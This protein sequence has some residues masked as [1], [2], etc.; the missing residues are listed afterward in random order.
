LIDRLRR[1]VIRL[2]TKLKNCFFAPLPADSE[3]YAKR[4]IA[5]FMS[6]FEELA[7]LITQNGLTKA[8]DL[9]DWLAVGSNYQNPG[10]NRSQFYS[11][12]AEKAHKVG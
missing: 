1:Q 5:F 6:L 8:S 4:Y 9:H 11:S 2:Q 7:S 3:V 12:V 10:T